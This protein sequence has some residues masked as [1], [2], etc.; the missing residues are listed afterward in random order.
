MKKIRFDLSELSEMK[1]F[2]LVMFLGTYF[3]MMVSGTLSFI[4]SYYLINKFMFVNVVLG[5]YWLVYLTFILSPFG[6]LALYVGLFYKV[7]NKI[8]QQPENYVPKVHYIDDMVEKA[9]EGDK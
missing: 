7:D 3:L 2:S 9:V 8:I 4:L 6:A 1:R 5:Q